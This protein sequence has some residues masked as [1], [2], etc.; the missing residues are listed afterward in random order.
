MLSVASLLG[1]DLMKRYEIKRINSALFLAVT[2]GGGV[3]RCAVG[4]LGQQEKDRD[5]KRTGGP[6]KEETSFGCRQMHHREGGG[7]EGPSKC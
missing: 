1:G 7:Y 3:K 2:G 6:D 5:I 4:T